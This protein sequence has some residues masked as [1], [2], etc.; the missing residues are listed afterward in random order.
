M[1]KGSSIPPDV[2]KGDPV[3]HTAWNDALAAIRR[4]A[5]IGGMSNGAGTFAKDG[6]RQDFPFWEAKLT[7]DLAAATDRL[8]GSATAKANVILPGDNGVLEQTNIEI[9]VVN[10]DL[11]T[12]YVSGE[13]VTGRVVYGQFRVEG[14]S[15]PSSPIIRFSIIYAIPSEQYAVCLPISAPE[16]YT[17]GVDTN[18][19]G[20]DSSGHITIYDRNGCFLD[21][22][23]AGVFID[24]DGHAAYL[25]PLLTTECEGAYTDAGLSWEMISL[26]CDTTVCDG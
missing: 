3:L 2:K 19:P 1:T 26:C 5:T 15:K 18:L 7:G 25:H 17:L 9:D 24:R 4:N 12:S 13:Y 8:T 6:K 14:P 11:N 20:A 16:G 21:D 23:D 10:W 22:N